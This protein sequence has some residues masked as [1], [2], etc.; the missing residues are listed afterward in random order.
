MDAAVAAGISRERIAVDPGIGFAKTAEQNIVLLRNLGAFQALGLPVLIGVSRKDFIGTYGRE[1]DPA[2]RVPG[3][4]A[5]ALFAL[6]GGATL[7]R[8]HDVAETVQAVR[9]WRAL[10]EKA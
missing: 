5:A 3:S 10:S 2:R 7:L 4:L 8:V 6:Q 1:P 9:V